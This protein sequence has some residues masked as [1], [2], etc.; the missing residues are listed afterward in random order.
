MAIGGDIDKNALLD[1]FRRI[2][3]DISR[4]DSDIAKLKS[5]SSKLDSEIYE[6]KIEFK[7]ILEGVILMKKEEPMQEKQDVASI[8]AEV[9][10]IVSN[11]PAKKKPVDP[12]LKKINKNRKSI[13]KNRIQLL[14]EQKKLGVSDIKDIIVDQEALCS[15]ATFYRYIEKM[16][17]KGLIDLVKINDSEVVVRLN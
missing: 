15:K 9:M 6:L 12:I 16:K 2:K 4:H 7:K 17:D 1:S 5:D 14:A 13:I 3:E 11:S 10:K 8:V